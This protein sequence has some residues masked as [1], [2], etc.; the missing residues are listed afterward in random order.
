MDKMFD[1]PIG[2]YIGK[3]YQILDFLG[4]GWEGEV[5]KVQE[6]DTT[7]V[8]VAKLFYEKK[9]YEA[10]RHIQYAKKL[11]RLKTCPI[12]IQYHHKDSFY[13]HGKKVSFLVSDYVDGDVLSM[14]LEKQKNKKL[15]SFE[16]LHVLYALTKGIEHIHFLGEY[17]GDIHSD[18]V[19]ISRCGLG[20]DVRLIDVLHLG[21]STNK[22]VQEDVYCLIAL[23]LELIGGKKT[24]KNSHPNIKQMVMGQK[25]TLIRKKFKNAGD[26]RI[27]LENLKWD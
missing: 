8:R 25:K 16:A 1:L 24:Y 12:I 17:H 7:I 26:I 21:R 9:G 11:F 6:V 2:R 14:Y 4:S 10:Q 20:Y 15:S 3:N 23:L 5:Y 13:L 27:Y 19:I 18:N 22:M